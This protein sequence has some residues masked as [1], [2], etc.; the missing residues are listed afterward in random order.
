MVVSLAVLLRFGLLAY[1]VQQAAWNVFMRFPI[2][3][4]TSAWY[5]GIGLT[6]FVCFAALALYG[7]KTS[8]GGQS[9]FDLA[10]IEEGV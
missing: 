10:G 1:I 8:L 4:D 6:G 2:T 3:L 7:F 9:A 5:F